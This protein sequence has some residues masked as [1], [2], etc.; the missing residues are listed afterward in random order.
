MSF[1]ASAFGNDP[2]PHWPRT[3][4]L[5]ASAGGPGTLQPGAWPSVPLP[6]SWPSSLVLPFLLLPSFL[7]PS[8]ASFCPYSSFPFPCSWF[9][10]H[11]ESRQLLAGA[12]WWR[13]PAPSSGPH[14]SQA[15]AFPRR[16]ACFLKAQ[17][18][19]AFTCFLHQKLQR[20]LMVM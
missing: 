4:L 12:P 5:K 18:V 8:F 11:G 16:Q 20:H 10:P 7:L 1:C 15:L 3:G 9:C 13:F 6:P 17:L 14:L 2:P 19:V